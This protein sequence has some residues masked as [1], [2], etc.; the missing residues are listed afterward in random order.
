MLRGNRLAESY[1]QLHFTVISKFAATNYP[2]FLLSLRNNGPE[3]L[4]SKIKLENSIEKHLWTIC[5]VSLRYKA[6]ATNPKH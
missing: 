3:K 4:K 6:K 5:F 2:I 1:F